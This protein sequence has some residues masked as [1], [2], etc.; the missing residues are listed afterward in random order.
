MAE[1]AFLWTS[2]PTQGMLL[3]MLGRGHIQLIG[4]LEI[5]P[6]V[7]RGLLRIHTT[8]II[9]HLSFICRVRQV[10]LVFQVQEFLQENASQESVSTTQAVLSL[11]CQVNN[12][13]LETEHQVLV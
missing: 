11:F 7:Q 10:V 5:A 4:Y 12:G 2:V 3:G 9:L 13:A 8:L 6:L 1:E